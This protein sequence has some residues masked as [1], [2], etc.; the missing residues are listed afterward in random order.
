LKKR[1][2]SFAINPLRNNSQST[3]KI[4]KPTPP[5]RC[6]TASDS[7]SEHLQTSLVRSTDKIYSATLFFTN[8]E[9]QRHETKTE[10]CRFN[11]LLRAPDA[12]H[13]G[14][15][16]RISVID[17]SATPALSLLD[18]KSSRFNDKSTQPHYR[19]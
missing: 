2:I 7:S 10:H 11:I 5:P 9:K 14:V 18:D 17:S 16:P 4:E 8:D 3:E 13:G 19:D 12:G 1:P 15:L 6:A